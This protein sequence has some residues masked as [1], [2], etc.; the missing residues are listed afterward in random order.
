[1]RLRDK[2]EWMSKQENAP[3]D[4][5]L[6]VGEVGAAGAA[7]WGLVEGL[8]GWFWTGIG[9]LATLELTRRWMR[10]SSSAPERV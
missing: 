6:K 8:A 9:V 1:M 7:I 2:I 4:T 3:L 5:A 10:G